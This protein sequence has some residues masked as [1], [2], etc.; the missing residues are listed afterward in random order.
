MPQS[1]CGSHKTGKSHILSMYQSD[2]FL[3]RVDTG[4]SVFR[5]DRGCIKNVLYSVL[6]MTAM[7]VRENPH[8]TFRL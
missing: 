5:G 7:G 6:K 1:H 2:G 4:F 8:V 3:Y